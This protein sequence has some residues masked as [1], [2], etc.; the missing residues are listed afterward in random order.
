MSKKRRALPWVAVVM[1][2]LGL[3]ASADT[4]QLKNGDVVRGKYLGGGE[5]AV[6]FE[7][8]GETKLYSVDQILSVTFTRD[9]ENKDGDNF[10]YKPADASPKTD[11]SANRP[12]RPTPTDDHSYRPD[13]RPAATAVA[14]RPDAYNPGTVPAGT[15][16]LI[17]MIDGVDSQTN[18][19]GDRFRASLES[20]LVVDGVVLAPKGTDIYGRLANAQEAGHLTGKAQLKLELTD[21]SLR[22]QMQPIVTGDYEVAGKG[23]GENTA[24]KTAG[25]AALGAI[26]GAIAGGGK[27]AAVGAAVGGGAGA[28][29]NIVTSGEQVRVPSETVLDFRL[30]QPFTPRG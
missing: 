7:V 3:T 15:H 23:R 20:D 18:H 19:V 24:E 6:Q 17:R 26:I 5:R 10:H 30:E 13:D 29:V 11:D 8:N 28:T 4:L 2:T 27:G 16:L 14:P 21:I 9:S 12:P 25:G 1:L 22:G